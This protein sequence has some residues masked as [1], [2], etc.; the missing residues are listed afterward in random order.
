MYLTGTSAIPPKYKIKKAAR[1]TEDKIPYEYH[2]SALDV[3]NKLKQR[4][5]IIVSLEITTTS[6]NI[7]DFKLS[8][9]QAVCLIIGAENKGIDQS[10]LDQSD[11]CIHI[12]MYG[13]NSSINVANAC[14]IALYEL[15]HRD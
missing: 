2:T 5:Y 11:Y 9:E 12:P 15:I 1:S 4:G 6:Q 14:A 7:R 13:K 3:V 8:A 10:L